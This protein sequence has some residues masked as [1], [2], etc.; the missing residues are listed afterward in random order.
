M[1]KQ[2]K[3]QK[4]VGK[5]SMKGGSGILTYALNGYAPDIQLDNLHTSRQMYNEQ[6]VM[7]PRIL[8]GR[9]RG[10]RKTK[11]VIGRGRRNKTRGGRK[12]KKNC[13]Y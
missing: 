2:N 11:R 4:R 5:R 9:G 13:P 8:G 12:S 1:S 6:S 7:N 10:N 3:T